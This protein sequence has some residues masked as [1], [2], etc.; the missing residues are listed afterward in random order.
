VRDAI[1]AV[2]LAAGVAIELL[3]CAGVVL[4][5]DPLDR[6]HY[7]GAGTAAALCVAVAVVVR[8]SFSLIGNKALALAA[9]MLVTG[10]VLAHMTARVA[11][12]GRSG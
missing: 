3:A 6:L 11:H 4:M 7:V 10:P 5:R 1:V 12:R 8:D 2:L 9:F